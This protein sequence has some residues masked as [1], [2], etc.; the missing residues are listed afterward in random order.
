MIIDRFA[1]HRVEVQ[2]FF[3]LWRLFNYG[4]GYGILAEAANPEGVK[5]AV[6]G[7]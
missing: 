5:R 1:L 4:N 3:I 2:N 6:S 7:K